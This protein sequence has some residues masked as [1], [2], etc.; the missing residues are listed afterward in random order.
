V[1]EERARALVQQWW[2]RVWRDG[3]LEALD[4]LCTD[5]YTRHTGLGTTTA[6]LE[7]YKK[8]LAQ[9][10][11][12]IKGAATTIDDQVVAGDR[13]WTRATSRGVNPA[14]EVAALMTWLTIHRI[15]GERL[16]EVWAAAMPNVDWTA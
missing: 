4:E 15:E 2:D 1:D 8:R 10:Q 14:G 16:A 12:T 11:T 3:D 6:S 7:D 13:V 9:A 5:P